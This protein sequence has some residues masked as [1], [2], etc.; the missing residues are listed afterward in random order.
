MLCVEYP[1][2]LVWYT[3]PTQLSLLN[4]M[5]S[6]HGAHFI[7]KGQLGRKGMALRW[8]LWYSKVAFVVCATSSIPKRCVWNTRGALCGRCPTAALLSRHAGDVRMGVWRSYQT[9]IR[10]RGRG[11]ARSKKGSFLAHRELRTRGRL[12]G[13]PRHPSSASP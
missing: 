7:Q 2:C 13:K 11:A 4:E 10:N 3:F 9:Q 5:R 1:K 12:V 6:R 8:S